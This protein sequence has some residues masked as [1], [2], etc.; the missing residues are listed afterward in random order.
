MK[1]KDV[2]VYGVLPLLIAALSTVALLSIPATRTLGLIALALWV[3]V[4]RILFLMA[5][6]AAVLFLFAMLYFWLEGKGIIRKSEQS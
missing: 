2:L 3:I 6:V 1:I 4:G 5:V